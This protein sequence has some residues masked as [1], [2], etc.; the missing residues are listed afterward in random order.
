M[1]PRKVLVPIDFSKTAEFAVQYA[2][3]F[4]KKIGAELSVFHVYS[5]GHG[6]NERIFQP[7]M[8]DDDASEIIKRE[9][10]GFQSRFEGA[11][12]D[13]NWEVTI[14]HP[15]VA[16]CSHAKKHN[17]D[18]IV[19]PTHSRSGMKRLFLGSVAEH[20][21][22]DSPCSALMLNYNIAERFA[23]KDTNKIMFSTSLDE[24]DLYA[25]KTAAAIG[26]T[27]KGD[28]V[29]L[30]VIDTTVM[31]WVADL[32]SLDHIEIT[33]AISDKV[34]EK[35]TNQVQQI[36]FK[37]NVTEEVLATSDN[38]GTAIAD[39]AEEQNCDL[40]VMAPSI[41]GG[42]EKIMLGSTA[43]RVVRA[44]RCPVLIAKQV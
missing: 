42:F 31:T 30:H 36:E 20:V 38:I 39:L 34:K 3:N 10:N 7:N 9:M 11:T 12:F 28:V 14:D 18:L 4:C 6:L 32:P 1:V 23:F 8:S 17:I 21:L 35:L 16:I 15:A 2:V 29:A 27:M 19:M 41:K 13:C 40:I 25:G 5:P 37:T 33:E 22:D 24:N 44:A 26:T 43:K